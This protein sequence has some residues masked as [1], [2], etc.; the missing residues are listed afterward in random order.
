MRIWHWFVALFILFLGVSIFLYRAFVLNVPVIPNFKSS[1]T[2][3]EA[4]L[5]FSTEESPTRIRLFLPKVSDRYEILDERF[6]SNGFA[7]ATEARKGNRLAHWSRGKS[8][9]KYEIYYRALVAP[10]YKKDNL[11]K[12][13]IVRPIVKQPKLKKK[14]LKSAESI[15]SRIPYNKKRKTKFTI[16][17]LKECFADS[18]AKDARRFCG[19]MAEE[20]RLKRVTELLAL[21]Q[22]PARVAHGISVAEPSREAPIINWLEVFIGRKWR[23][24]DQKRLVKGIPDDYLRWWA[25]NQ[26]VVTVSGARNLRFNLSVTRSELVATTA[27]IKRAEKKVEKLGLFSLT[28]LPV[29]TQAVYRLVLLIPFGALVVAF[30]RN[31]IGFNTL[32]T[33]MPVLIA[34]SFR[35]TGLV[36]GIVFYSGLVI[37]GLIFRF[38]FE[39][40]QLLLVPRL[41]AILTIVI[42]LMLVVSM[43]TEHFQINKGLSIALF[44]LVIL[45][46]TIE[47]MSIVS[48]ELGIFAALRQGL[49]SMLVSIFIYFL[50]TNQ[51]LEYW[52]FIFPELLLVN[53]SLSIILGRYTGY[54]LL[55]LFRFKDL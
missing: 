10:N 39:R 53:L 37:L 38:L 3:V 20:A 21:K 33:F 27:A 9:E 29:E 28:R 5:S 36:W 7:L 15:I 2:L 48:E 6:I 55:E 41:T 30:L 32:G 23:A 25:G 14:L 51:H 46:M 16:A 35:E 47:R 49:I 34:L 1:K 52:F 42:M 18:Q 22:I 50:L 8:R 45:T 4:H 26:E 11:Y 24:F 19:P 13:K 12:A 54:R 43:G 17:L 40:L 44:P 31:V